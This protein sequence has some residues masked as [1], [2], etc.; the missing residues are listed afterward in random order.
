MLSCICKGYFQSLTYAT[1]DG[2]GDVSAKTK[3][4]YIVS[5]S[6]IIEY[7]ANDIATLTEL[8]ERRAQVSDLFQRYFSG[9][10]ASELQPDGESMIKSDIQ[11]L[12]NTTVL[13]KARIRGVI[14]TRFEVFEP[15]Q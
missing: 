13:D 8:I 2:V 10:F 12:L 9:K 1:Y 6:P 11:E 14:F 5:L 7:D 15:I 4:N 3:D